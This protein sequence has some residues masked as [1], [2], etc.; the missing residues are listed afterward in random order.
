MFEYFLGGGKREDLNEMAEEE[1]YH[2]MSE[3]FGRVVGYVEEFAVL[4]HHHQETVHRQNTQDK[5]IKEKEI[6][7][8][9][10]DS[11][12]NETFCFNERKSSHLKTNSSVSK[13]T[14][15]ST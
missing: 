15:I 12:G 10:F 5:K 11:N 7:L 4:R 9:V 14:G 3:I 6:S 2:G 13:R 8:H 1:T